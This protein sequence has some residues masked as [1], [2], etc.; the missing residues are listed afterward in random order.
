M[1]GIEWYLFTAVIGQH[2]SLDIALCSTVSREI[3]PPS[4]PSH[5]L[6]NMRIC[7]KLKHRL[8]FFFF[9]FWNWDVSDRLVLRIRSKIFSNNILC[10][11]THSWK[12]QIFWNFIQMIKVVTII[13]CL[14][15]GPPLRTGGGFLQ[16][17]SSRVNSS[18]FSWLFNFRPWLCYSKVLSLLRQVNE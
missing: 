17:G 8:N 4:S 2:N 6:A 1:N 13:C 15:L 16:F 12:R 3:R 5:P 11:S 7:R 9:F 18:S 10:T 14:C